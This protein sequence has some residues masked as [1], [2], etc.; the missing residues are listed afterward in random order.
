MLMA[1]MRTIRQ[2]LSSLLAVMLAF[3][4]GGLIAPV[5]LSAAG[6]SVI[7]ACTCPG[8]THA[9]TCPMHHAKDNGSS[10]GANRCAIRGASLPGD[11]ALLTLGTGVGILPS[12][13]SFDV[14]DESSAILAAPVSSIRPRA[15]FP[16]SPPPR[17]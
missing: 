1:S 11:L 17:S 6:A 3:Q 14:A 15:D 12:L 5:A 4:L 8:G 7:E 13:S 2:R 9:T 10:T 16:D